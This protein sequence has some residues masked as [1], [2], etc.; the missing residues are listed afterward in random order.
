MTAQTKEKYERYL[1]EE[2][3]YD[4]MEKACNAIIAGEYDRVREL[5][6]EIVLTPEAAMQTFRSMGKERLLATCL[7][8]SAANDAFGEG[9]MDEQTTRR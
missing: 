1:E 8:L 3:Q 4:L 9:W 7:N 5:S 6:K 2:E